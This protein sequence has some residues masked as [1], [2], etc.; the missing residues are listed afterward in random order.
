MFKRSSGLIAIIMASSAIVASGA[1]ASNFSTGALLNAEWTCIKPDPKNAGPISDV[2]VAELTMSP[3]SVKKQGTLTNLQYTK[4]ELRPIK[5]SYSLV[6]LSVFQGTKT[7]KQAFVKLVKTSAPQTINFSVQVPTAHMSKTVLNITIQNPS[8]KSSVATCIPNKV[9][10]DL[11]PKGNFST[12]EFAIEGNICSISGEISFGATAPLECAKGV[13]SAKKMAEDSVATRAYRYVIDRYNAKPSSTPNLLLRIDPKAGNWK[14]D[15][16]G[17]IIAGA[18]FWGTSKSSDAAIPSYISERG[19]YIT[20]ML[21]A[22]G[23]NENAE[24]GKRNRDAAARGGG[25]AGFHGRYFDFIFSETSSKNTG[26]YQVGPHEYTHYAQMVLSNNRTGMVEREFWIDEGCATLIGTSMGSVLK[27]PQNQRAEILESI[28]NQ[29]D[30][31]PLKFFSRGSQASYAEPRFNQVYDTGFFA[32]EALVALKGIDAI[33]SVYK[34]LASPSA[35]YDTALT[36]VYGVGLDAL[37]PFLQNYID[38][39]RKNKVMTLLDLESGFS[40]LK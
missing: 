8:D 14:N 30:R 18:R 27:L 7:Y 21:K 3:T 28:S 20:E 22:D 5:G 13:W 16:A 11:L 2:K 40:K 31:L 25:Q 34:E 17:G 24:D 39:V 23:I 1:A 33:E 12:A 36:S 19:E 26:F 9:Y 10:K 6:A 32:C 29:K 37:I 4:F 15:V 35:N 38:S